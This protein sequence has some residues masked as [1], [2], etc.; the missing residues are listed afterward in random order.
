[1][2]FVAASQSRLLDRPGIWIFPGLLQPG[3]W[4]AALWGLGSELW[5]LG[6]E[7]EDHSWALVRNLLGA[8]LTVLAA[9]GLVRLAWQRRY[10]LAAV[11]FL[12]PAGALVFLVYQH[13]DYGAYKLILIGWWAISLTPVLG[14][15][16]VLARL[17]AGAPRWLAPA[18][19]LLTVAST[20]PFNHAGATR[21]C[22][23]PS[24]YERLTMRSFRTLEQLPDVVGDAP[25]LVAVDDWLANEWAVYFLRDRPINLCMFRMYMAV[26][27][28]G[29]EQAKR[30]PFEET[31]YVLTDDRFKVPPGAEQQWR[32]VWSGAPDG[33]AGRRATGPRR[34]PASDRVAGPMIRKRW[35]FS[36]G[37]PA[38][39][40]NLGKTG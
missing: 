14:L 13:Y 1:V 2:Q 7:G 35:I 40:S 12:L 32:L 38:L 8:L 36:C 24:P 3:C 21:G 20:W 34:L 26:E 31:R 10:A 6:G 27:W 16:A 18:V 15:D 4:P 28:Q 5:E 19:C 29:M 17:P 30:V 33:S 37:P 11:V 25:L 9:L 22:V 39:V 23:V